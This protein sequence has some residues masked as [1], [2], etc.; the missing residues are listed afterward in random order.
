MLAMI[1]SG[2]LAPEKLL[3]RTLSLE[4]SIEALTRMDRFEGVGVAVVTEF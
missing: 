4:Q 2:R 3:G 1:E